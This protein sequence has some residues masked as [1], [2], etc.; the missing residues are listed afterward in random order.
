[1][2]YGMR[3]RPDLPQEIIRHD[4]KPGA[5]PKLIIQE[6]CGGNAVLFWRR[7]E[8]ATFIHTVNG[9]P[10]VATPRGGREADEAS[11]AQG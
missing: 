3:F 2:A 7:R 9:V 10:L 8:D 1:M 6:V 4:L 11:R 5:F